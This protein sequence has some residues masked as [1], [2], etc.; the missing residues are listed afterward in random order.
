MIVTPIHLRQAKNVLSVMHGV[1]VTE[2]F[3]TSVCLFS[4]LYGGTVKPEHFR[5]FRVGDYTRLT[6]EEALTPQQQQEFLQRERFDLSL[7]LFAKEL[8]LSRLAA[9]GCDIID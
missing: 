4:W 8:V 5:H 3:K 9:T 1:G 7:Y 6:M 2:M